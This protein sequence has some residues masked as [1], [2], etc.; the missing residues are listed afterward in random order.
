MYR[1]LDKTIHRNCTC[2][3]VALS[4][5]RIELTGKP[6]APFEEAV[7]F[8]LKTKLRL[9]TSTVYL[10]MI[11]AFDKHGKPHTSYKRTVT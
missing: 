7:H 10:Y 3:Q 5:S 1:K 6:N 9:S 2:I 8:G 4:D 11:S